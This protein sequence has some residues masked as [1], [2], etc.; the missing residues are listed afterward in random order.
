MAMKALVWLCVV[1]FRAT[2]IGVVSF[3]ALCVNLNDLTH[4]RNKFKG[5][6]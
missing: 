4:L 2:W 3:G 1:R 6:T 5:K